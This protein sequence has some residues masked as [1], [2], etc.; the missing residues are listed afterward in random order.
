MSDMAAILSIAGV[1]KAYPRV[2]ALDGV[3][4]DLAP[5][6]FNVLLGPNGAGKSTLFQLLSGLFTPDAGS[7]AVD[8]HDLE[9][10]PVAVLA[11][12]GIVFQQATLD[13]DLSAAGN[14]RFHARLHGLPSKVAAAR[15]S[16]ELARVGL[17]D[18]ADKPCKELSGG[19]RRKVELA[20]AVLHAPKLLLMD[21]P[22]VG[23]DPGSRRDLLS[24]VRELCQT[25]GMSVLW[26]TH[27]VDE[28][29]QADRILVLHKGKL[30]AD[31]TGESLLQ[32]YAAADISQL[33][34][35]L[36]GTASSHAS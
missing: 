18:A 8:G 3:D 10:N 16:E 34:F 22:T 5:G 20:R 27:L 1:R 24:Y 15:I 13:L 36:T 14:L 35:S 19:N 11:R 4:I 9:K 28:T 31:G 17:S 25:R 23:L 33:F 30:A 21:E 32:E 26:A 29:R 12:L 7:I 2:Q 6:T